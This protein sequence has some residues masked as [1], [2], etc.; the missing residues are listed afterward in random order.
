M[1]DITL[2]KL[3]NIVPELERIL[4][5]EVLNSSIYEEDCLVCCKAVW[6]GKIPTFRRKILTPSSGLTNKVRKRLSR[7]SC[8][9]TEP[10]VKTYDKANITVTGLLLVSCLAYSLNHEDGGDTLLRS[11]RGCLLDWTALQPRKL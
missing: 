4:R 8:R 1:S 10:P 3:M 2:V 9:Q 11:L 7:S 6:F 5:F